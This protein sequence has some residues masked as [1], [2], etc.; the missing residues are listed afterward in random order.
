MT[1]DVNLDALQCI[2][3]DHGCIFEPYVMNREADLL[4]DTIVLV[5][6]AHWQGMKKLKKFDKSGKGGHVG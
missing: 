1:R 3:V 2:M 6:G 4:K 5:D